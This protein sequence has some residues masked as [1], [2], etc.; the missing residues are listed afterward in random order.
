[1]SGNDDFFDATPELATIRQWAH[2][3]FAAKWAVFLAVLLRVHA[4]TSPP[5]VQLPPGVIGGP[6]S[7]NLIGAFVSP[8][9]GGG[10]G[11]S[12]K[13]ARLAW[14][15]P[16]IERPIGSGEGI[17]ALFAPPKKGRR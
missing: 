7:L 11:I 2:A 13:V 6:A 14:P 9:S 16:I 3:R 12:D 4:S 1:M 5:G 15:A 10:K 17:A 8:P